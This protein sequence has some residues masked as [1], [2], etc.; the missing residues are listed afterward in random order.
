MDTSIIAHTLA[1]AQNYTHRAEG[2][3]MKGYKINS[4]V[5][6]M[7]GLEITGNVIP[8]AWYENLRTEE[9]W[10]A[11][12]DKEGNPK[13]ILIKSK[14]H[15]LAILLLADI[16]YWYRPIEDRE[17]LT[18]RIIGHRK[19]FEA[20]RL[21]RSYGAFAEQYGFPKDM[22]RKALRYLENKGVID[23]ELKDFNKNGMHLS[24][25]LYIGLNVERLKELI[26][27]PL[28]DTYPLPEP[29]LPSAQPTPPPSDT[30]DVYRDFALSSQEFQ[31]SAN[32]KSAF[33]GAEEA[34][35]P[36]PKT[37]ASLMENQEAKTPADQVGVEAKKRIRQT[38]KSWEL[39]GASP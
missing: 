6:D 19:K 39:S 34:P 35:L 23:L 14:P 22:V 2:D 18:G 17:E 9:R 5:S 1:F 7:I 8:A 4:V 32:A 28:P 13:R 3:A 31:D 11:G 12:K 20:D 26:T 27:L 36:E 38:I 21:Q 16:V 29:A 25:V 24:N 33:A 15:T 30:G 10:R 37:K